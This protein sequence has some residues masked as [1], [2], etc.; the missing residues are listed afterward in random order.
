MA[1]LQFPNIIG[2]FQQGQAFGQQQREREQARQNQSRLAALA[3]EAYSAP[4]PTARQAAIG[5][6]VGIDPS[7][8]L[9]LGGQ[10]AKSDEARQSA[11]VNSA[12]LLSSAPP[13]LQEQLYQTK[14][15]ELSQ[16][17]GLNLPETFTPEARQY[18]QSVV[19][20]YGPAG[21]VK[22]VGNSLVDPTGRVVYQAPQFFQTDAGLVRVGQQGAEEVRLGQP[23][24]QV[25]P[26]GEA[27][28]G[29]GFQI[30]ADV[31]PRLAAQI[32]AQETAGGGVPMGTVVQDQGGR[33]L[34]KGTAATEQRLRLSEEN[35][36]RQAAAAERAAAAAE[37]ADRTTRSQGEQQL[38]K[39][40][41]DR[42]K[43]QRTILTAFDK[44]KTTANN[45]TAANDLA[46]IFSYMKMLDPGSVVREGEFANAQNA[47]GVPDQV[48]NIY[49]RAVSGERLNPAQRQQFTQ[50]AQQIAGQAQS[51]IDAVRDEYH[52]IAEASGFDPFRAT[53]LR[54]PTTQAAPSQAAPQRARN[55]QT[56]QTLELRNGQWVPIDG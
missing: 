10:L 32:T 42:I 40:V 9:A 51:Q 48:L 56:G 29:Q 38:R 8:G 5:Q 20:T 3:Q 39:E 47:A 33:I 49:N 16:Q 44:V 17:F 23:P 19:R 53:G 52:E 54:P 13:E 1:E 25:G 36:E 6:A 45:P 4:D 50:S 30:G 43:D 24:A 15:Q 28:P 34:P 18:V 14:R 37:R 2:Q 46:L 27:R 41:S 21:D 31:D 22:V 11:I 26:I 55:P 12:R 7:A 35:A